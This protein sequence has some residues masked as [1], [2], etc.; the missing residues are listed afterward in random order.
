VTNGESLDLEPGDEAESH[1]LGSGVFSGFTLSEVARATQSPATSVGVNIAGPTASE[2][3]LTGMGTLDFRQVSKDPQ[4]PA[5]FVRFPALMYGGVKDNGRT[6][7]EA[8]VKDC[9]TVSR[10]ILPK[11]LAK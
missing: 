7:W 10:D 5:F 11:A 6:V 4:L 2:S 9:Q 3:K 1:F 8:T